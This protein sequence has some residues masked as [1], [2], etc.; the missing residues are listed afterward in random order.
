MGARYGLL[1]A[2]TLVIASFL[3]WDRLHP[4][5]RGHLSRGSWSEAMTR[6]ARI[7][8]GGSPV[9]PPPPAE[10]ATPSAT[11]PAAASAVPGTAA[12]AP[13]PASAPPA[14]PPPGAAPAAA[15]PTYTVR[16]GDTL[17]AVAQ[18]LLGTVRRTAE[19]A[20]LNGLETGAVLRVGTVLRLPAD[21]VTETAATPAPA[22]GTRSASSAN[23][24][25]KPARRHTV[26]AG[27]TLYSLA[28]RYYD[29]E[30]AWR[31]I[32]SANGLRETAALRVGE[33]LL[34][35]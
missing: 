31:R 9:L 8:V 28:R 14:T 32:R 17:G 33:T 4:P 27:D 23:A 15:A 13:S 2:L 16:S 24:D 19:L 6:R 26:A 1:A 30:G 7:V 10:A 29:D 21:A 11:P 18:R 35:P 25:G 12:G 5:S 34:I 3:V 20:T 22:G